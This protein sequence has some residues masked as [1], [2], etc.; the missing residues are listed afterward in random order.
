MQTIS[1]MENF[2]TNRLL[3]ERLP[4]F[5]RVARYFF[6]CLARTRGED[7]LFKCPT[8]SS[9]VWSPFTLLIFFTVSNVRL[10]TK[11]VLF[12]SI[13]NDESF[14]ISI[15]CIKRTFIEATL[16]SGTRVHGR[17]IVYAYVCRG[18]YN[19]GVP[20]CRIHCALLRVTSCFNLLLWVEQAKLYRS[21]NSKVT[22]MFGIVQHRVLF[23]FKAL[24]IL[25]KVG[26]SLI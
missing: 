17:S 11:C 19:P 18:T 21:I 13:N 7:H 22:P 8:T 10:T 25:L 14:P 26:V 3:S 24:K 6:C 5:P 16:L 20:G 4:S 9:V 23:L 12:S 15:I 1:D 2:K